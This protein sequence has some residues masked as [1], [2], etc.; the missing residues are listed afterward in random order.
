MIFSDL[1]FNI[2]FIYQDDNLSV[3]IQRGN[4]FRFWLPAIVALLAI[5][6]SHWRSKRAVADLGP[7]IVNLQQPSDESVRLIA[8]GDY[9]MGNE[10]QEAVMK[11]VEDICTSKGIHGILLLGDNIYMDGVANIQDPKWKKVIEQPFS[12]P[13]ISKIPLYPILGNHDYKGNP[14]AQIEY[15]KTNKNW[16]FPHRFYSLVIDDLL[17]VVALDTNVA[18]FCFDKDL[19]VVD[20]LFDRIENSKAKWKLAIGHHPV[21]GSSSKHPVGLQGK[22]LLP[23]LCKLDAYLAGHSHHLEHIKPKDC[24]GEFFI[25]GAGGASL[26]QPKDDLPFRNTTKNSSGSDSS[27]SVESFFPSGD[28]VSSIPQMGW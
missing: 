20:Y 21:I 22:L 25:S 28:S 11:L 4:M 27:I 26:Y 5:G 8:F 19:C 10:D 6:Y 14:N 23:T 1:C 17:E 13:C 15:T 18:D 9:G 2:D 3:I 24:K 7:R 16:N 12:K